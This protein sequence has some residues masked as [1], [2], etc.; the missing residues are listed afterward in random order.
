MTLQIVYLAEYEDRMTRG[1]IAEWMISLNTIRI[2][3]PSLSVIFNKLRQARYLLTRSCNRM[4]KVEQR[5]LK[6]TV[7]ND[8]NILISFK[9]TIL[10][11]ISSLFSL[12]RL[13][14]QLHDHESLWR[15]NVSISI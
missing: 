11:A 10:S 13:S 7:N 9:E 8:R 15:L 6:M 4:E 5:L 2:F 14:I 1:D 3:Q 12:F